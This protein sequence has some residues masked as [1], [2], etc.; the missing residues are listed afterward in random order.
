MALAQ[1]DVIAARMFGV[2]IDGLS[3]ALFQQVQ[4]ISHTIS[5]IEFRHNTSQ[6]VQYIRKLPGNH[7]AGDI[8]LKR[9]LSADRLLWDWFVYCRDGDLAP[10]HGRRHGS[11]VL[12]DY[13][14][15]EMERYN[16]EDGWISKLDIS[17]LSSADNTPVIEE[18]VITHHGIVLG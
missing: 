14:K 4:G 1:Y 3:T 18:C 11:I 12:F 16:F 2:E 9:G 6:G 13:Q 10:G 17:N 7:S 15:G 8:T 5:V